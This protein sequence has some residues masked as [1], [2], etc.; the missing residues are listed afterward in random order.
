MNSLSAA[1]T[2]AMSVSIA[3]ISSSTPPISVLKSETSK[4]VESVNVSMGMVSFDAFK[5][6]K[7][8]CACKSHLTSGNKNLS[9]EQGSKLLAY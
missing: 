9:H 8:F 5:K 2:S 1:P 6:S 3:S 7:V 4:V